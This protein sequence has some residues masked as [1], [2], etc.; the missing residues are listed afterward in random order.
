[1]QSVEPV[2]YNRRLQWSENT[3]MTRSEEIAIYILKYLEI[4]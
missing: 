3:E 2:L 1:M 4:A